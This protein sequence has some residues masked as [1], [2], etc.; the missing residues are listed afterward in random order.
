MP[1]PFFIWPILEAWAQIMKKEHRFYKEF[2]SRKIESEIF[3]P[4][5]ANLNVLFVAQTLQMSRNWDITDS[6]TLSQNNLGK[7]Y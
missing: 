2:K 5:K 6:A 4:L 1:C 3:W 7:I